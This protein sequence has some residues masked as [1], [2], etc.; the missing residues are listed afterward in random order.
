MPTFRDL[1]TAA[2]C[3]RQLYY[4]RR[5]DETPEVPDSVVLRRELAYEYPRLLADAD[6]DD[7]PIAVTAT[8]Y[9]SALHRAKARSEAWESL[10]DPA[11]RDVL[12]EGRDCRGV[13]HK[14]LEEPVAPS[15]LF[16][17]EPPDTGVWQPQSVR[18]VAAAL[19]LSYE[20]E[21]PIDIAFAE[22]PAHGV[23]RRVSLSA[24]RRAGY[25][26]T[27]RTVRS[28][29]GPPSRVR[30]RTKCETCDYRDSCGVR[31]RSLGSLL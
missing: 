25:R 21:R 1:A 6:L 17:G 29:D 11:D 15:L 3:P 10:V 30:N 23:V 7:E 14:I 2:Y 13:A 18:L 12:L 22:Y 28:I 27:L 4:R 5:D 31:T 19:A 8:Q 9:R 20:R 16:T 24:H 26:S